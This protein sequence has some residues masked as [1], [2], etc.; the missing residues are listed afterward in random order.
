MLNPGK[1]LLSLHCFTRK[2]S[3]WI[4]W[5]ICAVL[6]SGC[7]GMVSSTSRSQVRVMDVSPDAPE[8]D[9]YQNSSA[10]AYRLAFGTITSYV[11]VEPGTYTTTATMS[12]TRQ[13]LTSSKATL[14][15][16]GQYTVLIG[17][18]SSNLQQLVLKDQS[19]P[20]PHGQIALRFLH[21]A[22]RAGSVDIYLLPPGHR[23]TSA[24]PTLSNVSF[25]ANSGYVNLPA[26]T[27]TLVMVSA[28]TGLTSETEPAYSGS[29]LTYAPC[30]ASTVVLVEQQ[31]FT[32]QPE[33]Q[34]IIA[35]D[36]VPAQAE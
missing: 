21:Q 22:A 23:L 6:L 13:T 32:K 7:Q 3:C 16:A 26:G 19:Q 9:I 20:T 36:Y 31:S 12:G 24:S 4:A 17:N 35:P 1:P 8:I 14:A 5:G 30:S 2:A 18:F 28:G 10:I 25:G 34:A 27:Y 11:P 33:L 15:T 29:Q